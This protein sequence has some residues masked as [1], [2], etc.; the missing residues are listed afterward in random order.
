MGKTWVRI[1]CALKTPAWAPFSW[2]PVGPWQAA[3]RRWRRRSGWA[4]Q[5]QLQTDGHPPGHP[6][7]HPRQHGPPAPPFLVPSGSLGDHSLFSPGAHSSHIGGAGPP[8]P[9]DE[10][11]RGVPEPPV[12]RP[13]PRPIPPAA[14]SACGGRVPLSAHTCLR[15]QARPLSRWCRFRSAGFGL[16]TPHGV[17]DHPQPGLAKTRS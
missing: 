9:M 1:L 12:P 3:Q 6:R 15:G 17:D 11:L 14:D 2:L 16:R 4:V 8:S 5:G 10:S 7:A 13:G